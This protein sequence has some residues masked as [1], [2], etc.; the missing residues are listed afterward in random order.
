MKKALIGAAFI[1]TSLLLVAC[2]NSEANKLRGEF[3]KGCMSGG[4]DKSTCSCAYDKIEEKYSVEDVKRFNANP[5]RVPERFMRDMMNGM[6][7]CTGQP[8]LPEEP[9]HPPAP[10]PTAPSE[11][12]ALDASELPAATEDY[13]KL[14]TEPTVLAPGASQPPESSTESGE[15]LKPDAGL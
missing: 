15:A 7:V 14:S 9:S 1:A 8:T 11:A 2:G 6:L 10:S 13:T 3:L 12:P 4:T 5:E